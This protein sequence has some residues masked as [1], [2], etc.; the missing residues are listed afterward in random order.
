MSADAQ[1]TTDATTPPPAANGTAPSELDAARLADQE[2]LNELHELEKQYPAPERGHDIP[3]ARWYE[4]NASALFEQYRGEHVAIM[5]GA[6][7]GHDWNELRL[8][9]DV[10]RKYNVHPHRFL[11][12]YLFTVFG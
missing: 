5:N 1:P 12:V 4:A 8:R 3:D 7:V 2:L 9:R 10:A 11:V 6:V